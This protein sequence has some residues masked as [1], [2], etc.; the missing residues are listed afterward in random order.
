M[1]VL[2]IIIY[3]LIL[4]KSMFSGVINGMIYYGNKRYMQVWNSIL[5]EICI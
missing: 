5:P 3:G 1:S 2:I 4:H